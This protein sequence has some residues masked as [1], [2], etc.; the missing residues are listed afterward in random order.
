M[1]R[2]PLDDEER[3]EVIV[4]LFFDGDRN[5]PERNPHV[6]VPLWRVIV[7]KSEQGE[8]EID[9]DA[10]FY[11]AFPGESFSYTEGERRARE[12]IRDLKRRC[13]VRFEEII[14][15]SKVIDAKPDSSQSR[16]KAYRLAGEAESDCQANE[17][18]RLGSETRFDS[19]GITLS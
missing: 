6:R 1:K 14:P 10:D 3:E 16:I 8:S 18:F 11:D 9:P 4:E 17:D 5:D 19:E 7:W 2:I 13:V 12:V 15:A